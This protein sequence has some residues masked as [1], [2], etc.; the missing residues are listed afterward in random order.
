MQ[1]V[2]ESK[3][4]ILPPFHHDVIRVTTIAADI[5]HSVLEGADIRQ[6]DRVS[7]FV[8]LFCASGVCNRAVVV[9]GKMS[10]AGMGA[11]EK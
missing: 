7:R 11:Q 3:R 1:M 10:G 8:L 4:D 5:I 9:A 6:E 2:Q